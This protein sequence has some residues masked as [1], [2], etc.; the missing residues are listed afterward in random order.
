MPGAWI[1]NFGVSFSAS[2]A[3]RGETHEFAGHECPASPGQAAF[4]LLFVLAQSVRGPS[5]EGGNRHTKIAEHRFHT[6]RPEVAGQRPAPCPPDPSSR[7]AWASAEGLELGGRLPQVPGKG[8]DGSW[9][10]N[11]IPGS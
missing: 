10:G 11:A 2:R 4:A 3:L 8:A 9:G 1:F 6:A 5:Q 7:A